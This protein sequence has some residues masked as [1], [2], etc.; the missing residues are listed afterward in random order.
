MKIDD[1]LLLNFGKSDD[2]EFVDSTEAIVARMI[3][4]GITSEQA[5]AELK[6]EKA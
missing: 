4:K 3:E 6:R 1:S 2:E 5:F